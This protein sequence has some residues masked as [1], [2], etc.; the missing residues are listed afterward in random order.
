MT[1]QFFERVCG[2]HAVLILRKAPRV[3]H[4]GKRR[5]ECAVRRVGNRQ[6]RFDQRR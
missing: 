4:G 1:Q 2:R 3:E 5:V 6:R